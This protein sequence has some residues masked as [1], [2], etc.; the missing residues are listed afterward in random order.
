MLF[1]LNNRRFGWVLIGG[2]TVLWLAGILLVV[3][4]TLPGNPIKLEPGYMAPLLTAVW[5]VLT[6]TVLVLWAGLFWSAWKKRNAPIP[7]LNEE[8]LLS[9]E[10]EQFEK[11]VGLIFKH[12]GYRVN[13]RGQTGDHGVDLEVYPPSGRLG[14]V[15]CKRYRSTVGEKIVRDLYGTMLHENASHAYLVTAGT[16]SE[17]AMT[18]AADKPIT[19]INGQRLVEIAREL[20]R[21]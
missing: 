13:H 12:K 17:A 18:W 7:L 8:E 21:K 3:L 2:L 9:L 15:Q 5:G 14:V 4:E 16:F 6:F 1:E 11:H 20:A 10:P 19:L